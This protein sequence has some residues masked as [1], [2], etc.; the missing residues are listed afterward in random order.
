MQV[1]TLE[2]IATMVG[3]MAPVV[4]FVPAFNINFY[5]DTVLGSYMRSFDALAG[6]LHR[7]TN[8]DQVLKAFITELDI[9]KKHITGDQSITAEM[10]KQ[11]LISLNTA[12]SG[13]NASLTGLNTTAGLMKD[14]A[15]EFQAA[16]KD[17][18]A[19]QKL[20]MA[21]NMMMVCADLVMGDAGAAFSA[22][23]KW[24]K[25]DKAGAQGDILRAVNIFA[26]SAYKIGWASKDINGA[27]KKS[28]QP[29]L[30]T[31]ELIEQSSAIVEQL[32]S[33]GVSFQDADAS[34][35]RFAQVVSELNEKLPKM[36]TGFWALY[37]LFRQSEYAW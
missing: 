18:Q 22:A 2:S 12:L 14:A 7:T 11:T 37:A 13:M 10:D 21:F 9:Q 32:E 33:Q 36:G 29:K 8:R 34:D 24:G 25:N 27:M 5:S 1:S 16:L 6:T 3:S 30:V 20:K 31:N 26:D 35:N 28:K 23:T 4:G 19:A 15:D 17:Y